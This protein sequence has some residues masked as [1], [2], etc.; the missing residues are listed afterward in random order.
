MLE[1]S[2]T[3]QAAGSP[4]SGAATDK[5]ATGYWPLS[6]L[7]KCYGLPVQQARGD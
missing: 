7:K 3:A 6:K 4:Q 1:Q 5:D 2:Y